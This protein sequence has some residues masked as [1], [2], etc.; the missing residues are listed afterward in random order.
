MKPFNVIEHRHSIDLSKGFTL[1]EVLTVV[2]LV[3]IMS[4]IAAPGMLGFLAR[5]KIN[6]A[7]GSF[8]GVLQESQRA[9]IR[10]SKDCSI[11]M[12]AS[13]TKS[14]NT[15]NSQIEISG[16]CLSTGAQQAEDVMIRHNFATV[17]APDEGTGDS[18]NGTSVLAAELFDF[19]GSTDTSLSSNLVIVISSDKDDV[20]QKCIVVSDGLGLIRVGNYP[21]NDIST[22]IDKCSSSR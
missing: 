9:A 20:F 3:G 13:G 17:S 4:A 6:S 12:P 1:L 16:S 14:S 19:K 18:Y 11:E 5:S 10:E 7:L 15:S 21:P 2:V 22:A 8:Q